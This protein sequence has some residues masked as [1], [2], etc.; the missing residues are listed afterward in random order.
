LS[1]IFR[2][3]PAFIRVDPATLRFGFNRIWW[4]AAAK[5]GASIVENGDRHAPAA[6]AARKAAIVKGSCR[7]PRH[8]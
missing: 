5:I 1:T 6:W 8:R 7:S 3:V 2:A 4:R